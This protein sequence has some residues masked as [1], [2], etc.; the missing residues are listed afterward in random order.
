MSS[1]TNTTPE[2]RTS[3]LQYARWQLNPP[4]YAW[5]PDHSCR[6]RRQYHGRWHAAYS[7]FANDKGM[8]SRGL[9]SAGA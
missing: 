1:L 3:T 8:A 2:G 9:W 6:H 7:V 4:S 5:P